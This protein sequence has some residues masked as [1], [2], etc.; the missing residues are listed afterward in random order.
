MNEELKYTTHGITTDNGCVLLNRLQ[1]QVL[2]VL[3]HQSRR[4]VE[5]L[6]Q[7]FRVLTVWNPLLFVALVKYVLDLGEPPKIET[8]TANGTT[9]SQNSNAII[10][11]FIIWISGG[12]LK[13]LQDKK[14]WILA[15]TK[16]LYLFRLCAPPPVFYAPPSYRAHVNHFYII[17]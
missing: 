14:K 8:N 15:S 4:T 9:N 17:L 5:V 13:L 2:Q 6:L 11:R 10:Y 16:I 12:G 1:P 3:S 7:F